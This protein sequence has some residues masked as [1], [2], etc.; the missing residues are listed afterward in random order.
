[1]TTLFS[2]KQGDTWRC[3]WD[4]CLGWPSLPLPHTEAAPSW[5]HPA[6]AALRLGVMASVTT[7]WSWSAGSTWGSWC[8]AWGQGPQSPKGGRWVE[9]GAHISCCIFPTRKQSLPF[10]TRPC[11]ISGAPPSTSC[12]SQNPGVV[13]SVHLLPPLISPQVSPLPA[14]LCIRL[15]DYNKGPLAEQQK[16]IFSQFWRLGS[17]RP[18]SNKVKVS[19][20][21]S[22]P[23]L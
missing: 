12:V 11:P 7:A 8:K 13:L 19:G 20:E 21:S 22:L 3:L 14:G 2:W 17:P 10:F 16:C 15:S 9:A 1:M 6:L 18:K 4:L 5:Q 23:G